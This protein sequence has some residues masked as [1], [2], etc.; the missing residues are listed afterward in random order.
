MEAARSASHQ[1]GAASQW[2]PARIYLVGSGVFLVFVS[3]AGF[4]VNT[5]FPTDASQV[6]ATSEHI[7]G[8]LETNGWH[9]LA[10]LVS[11]IVALGFGLRPEWARVGALVKGVAYVVVTSA[12][13]IGGGDRLLIASNAADQVVHAS[14]AIGGLATA[15]MTPRSKSG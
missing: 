6:S 2:S 9:N 5:S 13:A 10:G 14:L 15:A 8:I 11:G 3:V 4:A 12:I 7:F 1:G